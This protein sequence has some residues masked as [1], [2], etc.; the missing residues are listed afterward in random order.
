MGIPIASEESDPSILWTLPLSCSPPRTNNSDLGVSSEIE[1]R[2]ATSSNK[3]SNTWTVLQDPGVKR[4][5]LL[6]SSNKLSNT[7]T[8]ARSRVKEVEYR[9]DLCGWCAQIGFEDLVLKPQQRRRIMHSIRDHLRM[10]RSFE[11]AQQK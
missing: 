11:A 4:V 2:F 10:N 5:E 7:W 1:G 6:S 8:V 9:M 3:L